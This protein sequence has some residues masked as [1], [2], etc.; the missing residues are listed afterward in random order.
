M[1][2]EESPFD[3][4]GISP[5]AEPVVIQAAYKAMARKYHPDLNP[6]VPPGE[7][8]QKMARINWALEELERDREGWRARTI[9]SSGWHAAEPSADSASETSRQSLEP[10]SIEPQ[11]VALLGRKGSRGDFR[12]RVPGLSPEEIRARFTDKNIDVQRLTPQGEYAVFAIQVTEDFPSA[13]PDSSVEGIDIVAAGTIIGRA[14]ASITPLNPSVLNQQYGGRIAPPRHVSEQARISFGKHKG[15][16]FQQVAVED[17]SYLQWMLG[18]G[19]GSLIELQCA[20][21]ALARIGVERSLPSHHTPPGRRP[22]RTLQTPTA[23]YS[24]VPMLEDPT[25]SKGLLGALKRLFSG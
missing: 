19:A 9:S 20:Q 13:I 12:V 16:T 14:F 7:L 6:G 21:L 18:Q 2:Q 5:N 8:N 24:K 25:K 23:R 4:L 17:P 11:V 15:R 1:T 3:I 22:Q 10:L